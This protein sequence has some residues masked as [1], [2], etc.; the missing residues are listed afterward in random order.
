MHLLK[1]TMK[2][3]KLGSMVIKKSFSIFHWNDKSN[4][5]SILRQGLGFYVFVLGFFGLGQ[6]GGII[7]FNT[8][9]A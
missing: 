3:T 6:G 2:N 4:V 1:M 9:Q 8:N 7:N 5:A